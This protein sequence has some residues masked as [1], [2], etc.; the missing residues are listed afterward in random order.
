[1]CLIA[2]CLQSGTVKHGYQF[3]FILC[4]AVSNDVKTTC[5]FN[6]KILAG[7]LEILIYC[8]TSWRQKFWRLD[9]PLLSLA[10]LQPPLVHFLSYVLICKC[11]RGSSVCG[12]VSEQ[13]GFPVHSYFICIITHDEANCN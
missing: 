12:L 10:S 13:N 2:L 1:M 11:E 9:H 3:V 7:S 5:Q 6:A 8:L 4:L